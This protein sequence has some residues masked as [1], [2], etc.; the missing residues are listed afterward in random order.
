MRLISFTS[1]AFILCISFISCNKNTTNFDIIADTQPTPQSKQSEKVSDIPDFPIPANEARL[2]MIN[3]GS[4]LGQTKDKVYADNRVKTIKIGNSEISIPL[5]SGDFFIVSET[6]GDSGINLSFQAGSKYY[7][8]DKNDANSQANIG[9]KLYNKGNLDGA[10]SAYRHA[11]A[12]NTSV[13][14][15]YK[16]YAKLVI[17]KKAPDKEIITA[18]QGVIQS[19][20]A[21]ASTYSSLGDIYYNLKDYAQ[22]IMN[23]KS[24][25]TKDPKNKKA[26]EYI[27]L[28]KIQTKDLAGAA[29]AYENFL[30]EYSDID[31]AYKILGDL[32][33][34]LKNMD[35][36]I[37]S[38]KRYIDKGH[39]NQSLIIK[40]GNYYYAKKQYADASTYLS[41]V[42]GKKSYQ[43]LHLYKLGIASFKAEKY[44]KTI[45][46]FKILNTKKAKVAIKKH[47]LKLMS[48]SYIRLNDNPKALF[49]FKKYARLVKGKNRNVSYLR[50]FLQEKSKPALAQKLYL[51]NT[52]KFPRDHRNFLRLGL[53]YSK[54]KKTYSKSVTLLKK[55][56]ALADTIP[57]A[58]LKIAK[59]Y[60]KLNKSSSELNAYRKYSKLVPGNLDASIRIGTILIDKGQTAEGTEYLEKAQEKSPDNIKIIIALSK[61]YIQTRQLDEALTLLNKAKKMKPEDLAIREQI[62]DIYQM[63]GKE[64]EAIDEIKQLLVKNRSNDLLLVYAQLLIKSGNK[65]DVENT[66]EDILATEPDNLDALMILASIYAEQKKYAQSI[67]LYKEVLM[68]DHKYAPALSGQ[69][70]VNLLRDKILWAENMYKRAL[71][72]DSNCGRAKLG[73]AKIALIRKKNAKY[74]ELV[75]KAYL[76]SPE[77]PEVKAEYK[78]INL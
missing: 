21:D 75:K 30:K 57:S 36:A 71:S 59:I 9:N 35:K 10:L 60:G 53:I 14:G 65:T 33:A 54:R 76:L 56:V 61:G 22:A 49:W 73:Q 48:E 51:T 78:K 29:Q 19:N 15:F 12:S 8:I 64:Q 28:C 44:K 74:K 20:E 11:I 23:Y 25:L 1:V 18:L 43:V 58:W 63:Q 45:A 31:T 62:F 4:T 72:A 37:S 13:R 46:T 24:A 47:A 6:P 39:N 34:V 68:I 40:T 27:A 70:D 52:K 55:A 3:P 2:V 16:N 7:L 50:A 41:M 67:D 42:K 17:D 5:Q 32:Y 66:I 77:D 26:L 69:G 38:Y